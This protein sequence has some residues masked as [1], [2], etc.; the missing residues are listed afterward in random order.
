[1]NEQNEILFS[2]I[3]S[4]LEQ[5][6]VKDKIITKLEEIS[7]KNDEIIKKLENQNQYSN[8]STIEREIT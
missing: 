5:I 7:V 8:N 1:M 4:L 6:Q 3:K 2:K